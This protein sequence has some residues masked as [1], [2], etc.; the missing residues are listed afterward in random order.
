MAG[1]AALTLHDDTRATGYFSR[2]IKE[3]PHSEYLAASLAARAALEEKRYD[4]LAAAID[5]RTYLALPSKQ[6]KI[7]EGKADELRKKVLALTWL[8]ENADELT[9]TLKN[10]TICNES[11]AEE[12]EKYA[13]LISADFNSAFEN[14]RNTKGELQFIWATLALDHAKDLAFRDR[15]LVIRMVTS[16]WNDADPLLQFA[17]LPRLSASIPQAFALNR[18]DMATVAPLRADERYIAR[19]VE[20]I[21]EM[22]NVAAKVMKLPWSRIRA[23]VLNETAGLYF[24][25]SKGLGTLPAPKNLTPDDLTAY[26]ETIRKLSLPFDEKG[27]EMRG[28][29]FEIASRFA[30]EDDSFAKIADPYFS[31]NPSLAKTLRPVDKVKQPLTL[32]LEFLDRLDPSG[33]WDS[34]PKPEKLA[35]AAQDMRL[36]T[37]WAQALDLKRWNQVAFFMQ[38]A[39]EKHLIAPGTLGAVKAVSLAA[40]GARGEALAEIED[41]RTDLDPRSRSFAMTTL[42]Q[43]SL[44]FC[45]KDRTKSLLKKIEMDHLTHEQASI[46]NKAREYAL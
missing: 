43:Y 11:L 30:I 36:K 4:F 38:E 22:E 42:V 16:H 31:E 14:A 17:F 8:S 6:L 32:A 1:H 21:R 9:N 39:Q 18:A 7:E 25:L 3:I 45:A 26:D 13:A 44:K 46:V 37:L 35:D 29:A 33:D 5:Y 10:K 40:A 27:Q 24:D 41:I 19:R 28:K 2:L 20:V 15:L 12:C 34:L 23:E